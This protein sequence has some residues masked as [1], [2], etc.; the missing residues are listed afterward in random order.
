VRC[1]WACI[2]WIPND[3]ADNQPPGSEAQER[4]LDGELEAWKSS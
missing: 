1:V 2:F 4:A 3:W